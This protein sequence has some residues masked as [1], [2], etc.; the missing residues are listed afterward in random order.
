LQANLKSVTSVKG[1]V[2]QYVSYLSAINITSLQQNK[3]DEL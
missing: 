2:R 3:D 1:A